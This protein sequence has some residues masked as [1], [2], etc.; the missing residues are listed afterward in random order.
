MMRLV[1]ALCLTL[2]GCHLDELLNP[3]PMCAK[4]VA[5]DTLGYLTFVRDGVAFDSIPIT[6]NAREVCTTHVYRAK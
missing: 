6:G 3:T 2:S 4:R 5:V 1:L